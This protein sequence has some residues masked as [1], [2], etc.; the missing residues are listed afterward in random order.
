MAGFDPVSQENYF[1]PW[2]KIDLPKLLVQ[3]FWPWVD[4]WLS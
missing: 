1:L 4:D 3:S 2:A